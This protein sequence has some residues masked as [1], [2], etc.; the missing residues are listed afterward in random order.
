MRS[1]RHTPWSS[2][3][4]EIAE[5]IGEDLVV[6]DQV[7][8][9]AGVSG[10]E[11]KRVAALLAERAARFKPN[12]HAATYSPLSRVLE[13]EALMAAVQG[14]QRLWVALAMAASSYPELK[15]FDFGALEERGSRQS[16]ALG[17]VHE[18]AVSELMRAG[19]R[20][21]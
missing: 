18:W 7:R 6:L 8:A 15:E 17:Q 12:G 11:L 13:L 10:G 20:G 21:N 4:R 16:E 9:A 19:R 1:N 3:L 2:Q 14:K 5:S